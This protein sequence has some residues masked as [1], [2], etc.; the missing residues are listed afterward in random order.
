L[1]ALFAHHIN[2]IAK[3]IQINDENFEIEKLGSSFQFLLISI[4]K[5]GI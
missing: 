2:K 5:K 4:H 3:I 1:I